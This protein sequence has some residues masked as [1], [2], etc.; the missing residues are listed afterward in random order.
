MR[1][2]MQYVTDLDAVT[3]DR[4]RKWTEY[5]RQLR[6]EKRRARREEEARQKRAAAIES[7]IQRLEAQLEALQ[8][9][10]STSTEA[11]Q[12]LRLHE[13]GMLYGELEGQLHE[14]VEAWG[15]LAA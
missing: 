12:T 3:W 7:E 10:I 8:E 15:E 14:K 6:R 4:A 9:E 5:Q 13:L 1:C 2:N 11:Q